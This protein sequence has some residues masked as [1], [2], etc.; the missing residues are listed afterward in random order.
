LAQAAISIIALR[1]TAFLDEALYIYA[2]EQLLQSK[3]TVGQYASYFSGYPDFYP[4]TA[5]L[6]NLLGGLELVRLFSTVCMLFVT[7]CV[8]LVTERLYDRESAFAAAALFA[9]TGPTLFLSHLATFDALALMF[10]AMATTLAVSVATARDNQL[11]M[12]MSLFIAVLLVLAVA[13]KYAALLW[14]PFVIAILAVQTIG[15]QRWRHGWRYPI[16]TIAGIAALRWFAIP[17]ITNDVLQGITSTTTHR[18]AMIPEPLA[19]LLATILH[20]GSLIWVLGLLGLLLMPRQ[21]RLVSLL[22]LIA[23]LAAPVYHLYSGESTSLYK[24][25][26]FALFFAAP[27]AGTAVGVVM[28]RI[29]AWWSTH[30]VLQ[31]AGALGCVAVL[32]AFLAHILTLSIVSAQAQYASWPSTS[33]LATTMAPLLSAKHVRCLCEDA[34][35]LEYELSAT[36]T[37]AQYTSP[38]YFKYQVG[39]QALIGDAAYTAAIDAGYFDVIELSFAD[40]MANVAVA[41]I[42]SG[43]VQYRRVAKLPQ[44]NAANIYYMVW[45]KVVQSSESPLHVTGNH[46]AN[47]HGQ[48][49]SSAWSSSELSE[50]APDLVGSRLL[51]AGLIKAGRG[52]YLVQAIPEQVI[53]PL[54]G[55]IRVR[56]IGHHGGRGDKLAPLQVSEVDILGA[57]LQASTRR[58]DRNVLELIVGQGRQNS[59]HALQLIS[60]PCTGHEGLVFTMVLTAPVV[61][62]QVAVK[63]RARLEVMTRCILILMVLVEPRAFS[64]RMGI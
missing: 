41:A 11:A 22:L 7:S 51:G 31:L 62:T 2:G 38:Y 49:C 40:P 53:R 29:S 13:A 9:F 59:V 47:S 43:H 20:A 33:Q 25:M 48:A 15:Q 60:R 17:L 55:N 23:S 64:T 12:R 10:L 52:V 54:L 24:H 35:V 50:G 18:I 26:S 37:A 30:R 27:V 4:A 5:G 39:S 34:E 14:V 61:R 58:Q 46:L 57:L 19:M 44:N 56:A 63:V 45:T 16:V 1:N 36:T 21:Q 28:K 32:V 8:F 3:A 6:L 42:Q